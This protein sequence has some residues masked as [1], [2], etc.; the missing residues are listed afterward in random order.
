MRE[1]K[2][3]IWDK[4][5]KIMSYP[6]N[7]DAREFFIHFGGTRMIRCFD[8]YSQKTIVWDDEYNERYC[9]QQYIDLKDKNGTEIYEGDIFLVET[10]ENIPYEFLYVVDYY[11]GS[12]KQPYI[13]RKMKNSD[14]VEVVGRA[15]HVNYTKYN[16]IGNIYE[17]PLK[18]L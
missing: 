12:Y 14:T 1:L 18:I 9:H 13:Y 5:I 16:V 8:G 3:R 7:N 10:Y 17:N 15:A 11:D 6:I 4:Q 2:F